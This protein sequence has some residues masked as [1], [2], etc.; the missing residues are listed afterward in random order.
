MSKWAT[1]EI[2]TLRANLKE[3]RQEHQALE[4]QVRELRSTETSSKVHC[5]VLFPKYNTHVNHKFKVESLAQQLQLSQAEVER[6]NSELTSKADEFSKYRRTKHSELANVQ[7]SYDSLTQTHASTQATLKA[8]QSAHTAQTHQATQALEKIQSL[9]SQLAVQEAAYANEASGLRKLVE[10]MEEREK[11]AKH[12]VETIEREWSEIGEK[13]EGREA[14]LR[15]EVERE[16]KG[17]EIAEKRAEQMEGLLER[18][19]RGELPIPG[20]GTPGTPLRAPG[21]PDIMTDGI[22][23]LSPTVAMAS[24]AQRS[25]KTFTE[26][27]ADYVRLQDEYARKSAE[28]DHMDRTLS[29]VLAQ[30]EERVRFIS[31]NIS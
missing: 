23:G 1:D 31:S 29:S 28:Y 17:R 27:Y 6:T 9:T 8:L 3:A 26:V 30:I 4:V 22:I 13:A 7:A 12:V 11:N 15:D 25:G 19:R 24:K 5:Y 10:M 18:V 2:K 21:T 16:R 14:A 20:H